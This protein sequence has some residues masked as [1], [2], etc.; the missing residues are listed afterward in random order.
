[1]H[2]WYESGP[3]FALFRPYSPLRTIFQAFSVPRKR[4]CLH[5]ES[6]TRFRISAFSLVEA[7]TESLPTC[8]PPLCFLHLGPRCNLRG[9][10]KHRTRR[11]RHS[12]SHA[13]CPL[14]GDYQ[15]T[16]KACDHSFSRGPSRSRT[17]IPHAHTPHH[18]ALAPQRTTAMAPQINKIA[19]VTGGN[20]GLGKSIA[21]NLAKTG[22]SVVITYNSHSEEGDAVVAELEKLGVAG[23][24]IQLDVSKVS[25]F[26]AF[27][28]QF[29]GVLSSWGKQ[30]F[31]TFI[32]SAGI[33]GSTSIETVDEATVDNMFAVHVKGPMFLTQKLLPLLKPAPTSSIITISSG[34]VRFTVGQNGLYAPAK[35]AVESWT[36]YLAAELGPKGGIRVV[37]VRA[38]VVATD[39]SGGYLRASEDA[40]KHF[41]SVTAL[42][43]LA[44]PDD[45]GRVFASV[46]SDS[47]VW[48]TGTVIEAS[49][50]QQL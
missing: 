42:R 4:P 35:A 1:M 8:A 40:Q 6:G 31:D 41:K 17:T 25:G 15:R 7:S 46:A 36:K 19:L 37:C 21:L 5:H 38:G 47:F 9:V 2:L 11:W 43:R 14:F 49:G 16:F 26:D 50:G 27:V 12:H 24:A 34:L 18:Q 28:K 30:Q 13:L 32:P 39:F 3:S 22:V 20:R 33:G 23:A 48:V 10:R 29:T 45:I 44:E